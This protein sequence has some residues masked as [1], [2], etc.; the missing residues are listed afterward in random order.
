MGLRNVISSLSLGYTH[1]HD[2]IGGN[3]AFCVTFVFDARVLIVHEPKC[4]IRCTL[5]R[6][7]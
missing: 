5:A 6:E 3:A 4:I 1:V 2:T 7:L